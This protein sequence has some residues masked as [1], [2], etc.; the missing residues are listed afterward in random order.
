MGHVGTLRTLYGSARAPVDGR[1]HLLVLEA[2]KADRLRAAV[3]PLLRLFYPATRVANLDIVDVGL[4]ADSMEDVQA[5]F[6]DAARYVEGAGPDINAT[7][8]SNLR[9]VALVQDGFEGIAVV[10]KKYGTTL[11]GH[12]GENAFY[13]ACRLLWVARYIELA[14]TGTYRE[15]PRAHRDACFDYVSDFAMR[16]PE[17]ETW[18]GY[19]ERERL[20]DLET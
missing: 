15:N 5:L 10:G 13:L 11:K 3:W 16:Y 9:R 12:E 19:V 4:T 20:R 6:A 18:V 1:D 14:G 2:S 8:S 7:F 17:G